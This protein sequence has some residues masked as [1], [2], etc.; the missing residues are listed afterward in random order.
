MFQCNVLNLPAGIVPM[1][2]VT[3]KDVQQMKAYPVKDGRHRKVKQV[4]KILIPQF[5]GFVLV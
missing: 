3:E 4:Q 1:T 2:R 5:D